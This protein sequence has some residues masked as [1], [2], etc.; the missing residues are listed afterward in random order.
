MALFSAAVIWTTLPIGGHY[1]IDILAGPADVP[2]PPPAIISVLVPPPRNGRL[3]FPAV[4]P[5]IR[6]TG[7]NPNT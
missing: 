3:A 1:V 2:T 4:S 5:V 7:G 6:P